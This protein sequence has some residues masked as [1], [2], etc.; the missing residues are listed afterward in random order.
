MT[1][2]ALHRNGSVLRLELNRPEKLNAVD[3]P[4]LQ[5]LLDGLRDGAVD[6]TVRVIQLTGAGRAFCA[7]GDLTGG[8]TRGAVETANEVVQAIATMPKPVI[9]G[10]H[11]PALGLGCSL[12]LV[13]D[14]VVVAESAYFQL[15]FSKVGLML[16]GGASALLPAAIGR[17]R[18]ARI[19]MTAEKVS[20]STAFEWG[21]IS[22]V[23]SDDAYAAELAVLTTALA[24]GPTQAYAWIKRALLAATLSDLRAVQTVEEQGQRIL[25]TTNDFADGKR[26]FREQ[27]TARFTGE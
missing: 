21:M 9:A 18:A 5:A 17:A 3:T 16:D 1:A 19:A 11:G 10:V 8:D 20:A 2:I 25:V 26:A 7:G 22:H 27:R 4:T 24:D 23:V 15:A 6:P 14:L 12:A 13:C